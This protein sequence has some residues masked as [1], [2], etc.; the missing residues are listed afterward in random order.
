MAC[1]A[2]GGNPG[3]AICAHGSGQTNN[4]DTC[5]REGGTMVR[6]VSTAGRA[7]I[8]LEYDGVAALDAPP[9]ASGAGSCSVLEGSSDDKL[10]V[11]VSTAGEAGPWRVVQQLLPGAGLPAA[12]ERRAVDLAAIPGV[13]DNERF[14]LK[15]QWQ[16]NT[17][18]ESGRIDNVC[19]RGVPRSAD[20][21]FQRGDAN[22]DGAWDIADPIALLAHLFA[23]GALPCLDAADANDSGELNIADGIYLLSY[24]FAGGRAPPAPFPLCGFDPGADLLACDHNPRCL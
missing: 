2:A 22:G 3:G 17:A 21:R 20:A 13:E 14:A 9:G 12:W 11:Y 15:F 7:A 23:G 19:L 24:V 6:S 16:L 1:E 8:V 10:V 5:N 4:Q 18:A